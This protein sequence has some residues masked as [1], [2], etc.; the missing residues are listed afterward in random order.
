MAFWYLSYSE[1]DTT[2]AQNKSNNV[3][4]KLFFLG[5]LG[6]LV[7]ALHVRHSDTHVNEILWFSASTSGLTWPYGH[8][9]T[10]W[11]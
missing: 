4:S 5:P 8:F 6:P 3:A 1:H 11:T 10:L 7:F 2:N 9:L